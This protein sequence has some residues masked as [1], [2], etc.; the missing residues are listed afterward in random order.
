MIVSY[1]INIKP[2]GLLSALPVYD[3]RY[4]KTRIRTY[5]D[6]VYTN[7]RGLNVREDHIEC[8]CAYKIVNKHM[9]DF[10]DGSLFATDKDYFFDFDK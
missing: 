7:F 5:G 2:F 9:S 4:I 3:D 8:D 10:L 1:Y 6:K